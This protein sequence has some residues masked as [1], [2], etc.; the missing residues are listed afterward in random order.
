MYFRITAKVLAAAPAAAGTT[1][2]AILG[3]DGKPILDKVDDL[4]IG[5]AYYLWIK[6]YVDIVNFLLSVVVI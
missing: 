3:S 1:A 5:K 6:E 2:A 4:V